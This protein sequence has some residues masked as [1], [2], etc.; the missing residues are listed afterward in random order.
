MVIWYLKKMSKEN[1]FCKEFKYKIQKYKVKSWKINQNTQTIYLFHNP[2][3]NLP[4]K[5]T[6]IV[7]FLLTCLEN[8]YK[9]WII[10]ILILII[11]SYLFTSLVNNTLSY[12]NNLWWMKKKIQQIISINN[13]N[14]LLCILHGIHFCLDNFNIHLLWTK[15]WCRMKHKMMKKVNQYN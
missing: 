9:V 11:I 14:N 6:N 4:N 12:S 15:E 3:W 8:L 5:L 1:A 10:I 7:L 13:L 2:I